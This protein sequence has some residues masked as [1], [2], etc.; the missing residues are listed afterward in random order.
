MGIPNDKGGNWRLDK[1]VDYQHYA[2]AVDPLTYCE[3]ARRKKLNPDRCVMLAWF[4]SL[5]Y[6][7]IT[8]AFLLEQLNFKTVQPEQVEQ[9]WKE[10]KPNLIFGSA[11]RY[12]KNMDW[13]IP[14]MDKFMNEIDR[15]PYAWLEGIA[16]EGT[17]KERYKNIELYLNKWQFMGRFSVDLFT[18]ALIAMYDSGLIPLQ[19][20]A[21]G[22][23]WKKT[24]NL[25]SGMLNIFY[26]DEEADLFDKTGELTW[27]VEGM[28]GFL[29]VVLKAVKE[30]YPDQTTNRVS[31]IN[32]ICSFRNLFKQSR[33]GGFHHDRQLGNLVHYEEVYPD[34]P[35]WNRFYAIRYAIFPKHML[36]EYNGWDGIRTKRKKLWVEKGMT[37]VETK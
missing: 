18:E 13:F 15:Q 16:G 8:A 33:Y 5:T 6:C 27:G 10:H 14:L 4:H 31:I 29:E 21:D 2:P 3:Y 30:K 36:G 37:G 32:K 25:T 1:F 12:V 19:I 28:D 20:E 23:D 34:Y 7:E 24:S 35:L 17:S 11:R 22:Y 26:L 9:F